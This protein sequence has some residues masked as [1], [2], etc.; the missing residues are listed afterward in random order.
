[1]AQASTVYNVNIDLA[2]MD[3]GVYEALDLRVA[4]HPSETAA[5]MLVRLLAY[6][7]EYTAGIEMT[8]G[9]SSADEP[10]L[11]VRDLTGRVTKWIEIGLPDADRL[12]RG[13]KAAGS[14]VV[15]THRDVRQLLVQLEGQGVHRA[16]EIPIRAFDRAAVDEIADLLDRRSSFS[17]NVSDGELL[18]S[19]GERNFPIAMTEYRIGK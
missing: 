9:L 13:S 7:L 10:A 11:V 2:D 19:I 3:R 16:E 17:L 6:C 8:A 4:R 1:M 18:L 14:A 5:F 12:H 15:Y